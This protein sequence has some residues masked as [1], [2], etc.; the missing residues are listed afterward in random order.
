MK[1]NNIRPSVT[2]LFH[3]ACFQDSSMLWYQHFIS[4]YCQITSHFMVIPHFVSPF[5][6]C[7]LC[8]YFL[9]VMNNAPMN[10]HVQ[11]FV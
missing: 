3:I 2:G 1:S 10:I 5:I 4:F 6:D 8:F 7:H 9:A 11:V